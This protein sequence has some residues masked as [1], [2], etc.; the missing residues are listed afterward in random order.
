METF[1]AKTF[2]IS[3]YSSPF[4]SDAVHL[5]AVCVL[6]LRFASMVLNHYTQQKYK[7]NISRV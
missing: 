4:A 2:Q 3:F 5:Q 7:M 1:L 6:L